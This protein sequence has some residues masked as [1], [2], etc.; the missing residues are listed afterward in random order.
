MINKVASSFQVDVRLLLKYGIPFRS[1][2]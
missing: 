2:V 1:P